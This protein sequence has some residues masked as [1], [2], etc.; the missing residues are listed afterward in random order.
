MGRIPGVCIQRGSG[1]SGIGRKR[2]AGTGISE[3]DELIMNQ[4]ER[5]KRITEAMRR[6]Y[7]AQEADRR[8]GRLRPL[9]RRKNNW[10]RGGMGI[11]AGKRH[12]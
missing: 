4:D 6:F 2:N 12:E 1:A 9:I 10:L 5:K 3:E 8:A 11:F 7:E